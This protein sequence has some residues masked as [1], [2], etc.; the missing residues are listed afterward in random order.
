MKF[1]VVVRKLAKANSTKEQVSMLVDDIFP[2]IYGSYKYIQKSLLSLDGVVFNLC[3]P[4]YKWHFLKGGPR[5]PDTGMF[6]EDTSD[7]ESEKEAPKIPPRLLF[8]W[9]EVL[10]ISSDEEL[11][12][13]MIELEQKV[14]LEFTDSD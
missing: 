11:E 1:L 4:G 10:E 7:I 14:S 9:K 8:K 2:V 6:P 3:Y 5:A 12:N 13:S